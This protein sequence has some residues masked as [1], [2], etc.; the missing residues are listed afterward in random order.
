MEI[1][2]VIDWQGEQTEYQSFIQVGRLNAP[3]IHLQLPILE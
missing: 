3:S 2:S 1:R